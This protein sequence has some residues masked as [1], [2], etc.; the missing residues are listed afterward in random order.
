MLMGTINI[1]I[2]G[3]EINWQSN[4]QELIFFQRMEGKGVGGGGLTV[5]RYRDQE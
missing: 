3:Y 4:K 5:P 2:P 1:C